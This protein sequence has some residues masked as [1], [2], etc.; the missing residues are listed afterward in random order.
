MAIIT[1]SVNAV[2]LL[3]G[4]VSVCVDVCIGMTTYSIMLLILKD[5]FVFYIKERVFNIL[6]KNKEN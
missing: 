1:Y 5:E 3:K 2:F 4:V 6:K